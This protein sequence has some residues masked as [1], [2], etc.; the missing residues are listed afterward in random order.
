MEA[1]IHELTAGYALDALDPAER[2]AFE[3][4][5]GSCEQ[6]QEELASFWEVT[7][8]LAVAA[9]GPA[10]SATLRERIVTS[11]RAE[12]QTVVPLDSRRRVSPVLAAVTAIAAAVAIGL[13]IYSISLN[14]KLDDSRSA[15][16]AQESAT[17]VLA[18]PDATTV[19]LQS[20]S[21]RVVVDPGGSA[22]LVVDDLPAA[23]PGKTYQAWVVEG[24]E[25]PASAGTFDTTD[26]RAIVP[27]PTLVPDGAVIGVTLESAGGASSPTL[28]MVAASA[29]V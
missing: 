21:G 1:G 28:P 3:Q 5:L 13:G 26:K 24:E 4:H 14:G 19:A 17:A 27:L 10:P 12:K 25:A 16:T 6:C 18:D 29:P 11:A 7:S 23:P 22:V 9:D 2:D 8:A 20:G 15:L